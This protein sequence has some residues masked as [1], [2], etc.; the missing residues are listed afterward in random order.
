M[1][2]SEVILNTLS[3]TTYEVQDNTITYTW[4]IVIVVENLP[5]GLKDAQ[6]YT[7]TVGDMAYEL[8]INKFNPDVYSGQIS[9][10]K[11]TLSEVE[12]GILAGK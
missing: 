9:S 4:G 6:G 8:K 5:A 2:Q 7:I 11:H 3:E 10:I 1:T 12:S